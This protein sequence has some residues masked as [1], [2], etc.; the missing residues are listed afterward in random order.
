MQT[1]GVTWLED[2]HTKDHLFLKTS[3]NIKET[4]ARSRIDLR[5]S[6]FVMKWLDHNPHV[7]RWNSECVVIPY[8][9]NADGK[10]RRYF[11]DFYV[12][13]DNGVTYLWEVKPMKETLPPPKP[14]NNNVHNKKKFVDAL[15]VYSVNID[16]WKAANAACKAKGW[17]FKII[18]ED[19]LKR[20]FGW[21]GQ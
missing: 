8:F 5:G 4:H 18:T 15:Y 9:S 10:R 11:M 14:A 6:D 13:M 21:K 16:K 12:E 20:V 1:Q 17:E 19:T 3:E 7:K 2:K